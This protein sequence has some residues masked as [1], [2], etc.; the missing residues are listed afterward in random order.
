MSR[1]RDSS[2]PTGRRRDIPTLGRRFGVSSAAII[3][4]E[5]LENANF[6]VDVPVNADVVPRE[7]GYNPR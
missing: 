5:D 6:I 7:S 2:L 3:I 4:I 1:R